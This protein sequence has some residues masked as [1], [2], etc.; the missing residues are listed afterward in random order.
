MK[1][2]A[3]NSWLL[4]GYVG[5]FIIIVISGTLDLCIIL[6][7]S[8]DLSDHYNHLR[9]GGLYTIMSPPVLQ[10]LQLSLVQNFY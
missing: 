8:K 9:R 3:P 4:V 7:Y 2:R 1:P 10:D 5:D 6:A